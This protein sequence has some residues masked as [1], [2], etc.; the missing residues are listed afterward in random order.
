MTVSG[1]AKV[2][3]EV[4]VFGAAEDGNAVLAAMKAL[5]RLLDGRRRKELFTRGAARH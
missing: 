4:I 5:P 2:L 1:F 3:T